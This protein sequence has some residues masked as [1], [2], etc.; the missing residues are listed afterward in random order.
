MVLSSGQRFVGLVQ[1]GSLVVCA[2]AT[3]GLARRLH[4]E[5][6]SA[7]FAGALV[8]TLPVAITQAWTALNDVAVASLIVTAAYFVLGQARREYVLAGLAAGLAIGTK[9]TGVLA[10]PLLLVIALAGPNRRRMRAAWLL[11]GSTLAGSAWYLVISSKQARSTA[12]SHERR[13]RRRTPW[14][15]R[16]RPSD[17]SF[18]TTSTSRA[19]RGEAGAG[20]RP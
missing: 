3:A 17:A 15:S 12:T 14:H 6:T 18:S 13:T 7:L 8:I 11:V 1:L 4:L 9:F 2:I 16:S 5:R 20:L 19:H 10:L